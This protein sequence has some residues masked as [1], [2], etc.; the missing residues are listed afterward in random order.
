MSRRAREVLREGVLHVV[1][2]PLRSALSAFTCAVAIAVTVNVISL[3]YGLDE[4][5]R[6]DVA[7]FGMNTIDV[8]RIPAL[9]PGAKKERLGPEQLAAIRERL[10]GLD[11]TIAPRRQAIGR[12]TGDVE[13]AAIP[14]FAVSP[15]YLR[16]IEVAVLA[17]RWF[18]PGD[19]P[20]GAAVLD[21]SAAE[22]LFPGRPPEEAVGRTVRV[23]D[24]GGDRERRVLGVLEDPLTYR[25]LFEAFDEGRGSRTLTSSLLSFRNVYVPEG[26]LPGEEYGA[27][28]VVLPDAGRLAEAA[29]RL[30][31]V[32]PTAPDDAV[33]TT[34]VGVFVRREWMESVGASSSTGAF[35]GNI[36]WMIV[37]GVAVVMISTLNLI[38]VR[39]RYDEIAVRRCEGARRGDVAL[40]ITAEGTL[41]ALAGGLA[42]LPLGYAGAVVLRGVVG[43]PFR[44]EAPYAAAATGIAVLL[45]LL[46]SVLPARHAAGLQPAGVLTRRQT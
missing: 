7:R 13:V 15:E 2:H 33:P 8:V 46:A 5:V 41:I 37:V 42:G 29:R 16:T 28:S 35:L 14:V 3:V 19:D 44:F 4:D 18:E 27:V 1:R 34:N 22:A 6:K 26:A 43:F 31:E 17:G 25:E 39:E 30:R 11:A 9:V 21:R 23:A 38:V 10:A 45:G 12:A 24:P 40:Q 36:V 32:W 20:A